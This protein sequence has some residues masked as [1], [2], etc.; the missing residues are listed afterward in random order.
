M[1]GGVKSGKDDGTQLQHIAE[2]WNINKA[3]VL[4]T[5]GDTVNGTNNTFVFNRTPATL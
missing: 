3:E 1:G 4:L 2:G 5:L